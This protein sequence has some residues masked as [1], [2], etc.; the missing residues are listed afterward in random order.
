M[1]NVL[2]ASSGIEQTTARSNSV[3]ASL[4]LPEPTASQLNS[5]AAAI[6]AADAS[7]APKDNTLENPGTVEELH[8]K[9]KGNAMSF[10][11]LQFIQFC[12][13]PIVGNCDDITYKHVSVGGCLCVNVCVYM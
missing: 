12:T 13:I 2:A 4:G 8:K 5:E 11:K 6:I 7:V 9:C 10:I 3:A 1:G